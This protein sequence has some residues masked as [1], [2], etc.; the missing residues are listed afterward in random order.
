MTARIKSHGEDLLKIFP[1]A[2]EKDPVKLCKTLFRLENKSHQYAE[3]LCNF[4]ETGA[5]DD[6]LQA[7]QD[8]VKT[9]L[10]ITPADPAIFINLDPRG[11]ALKITTEDAKDLDIYKDWGG[12]GIIAP[13][14]RI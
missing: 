2:T 8:R 6:K 5:Y 9:L 4:A 14:F 7:M 10:S 11:Y 3:N 13:D 1:Q 12:Y